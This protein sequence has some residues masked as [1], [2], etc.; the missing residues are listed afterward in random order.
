LRADGVK[1]TDI[2]SDLS[3]TV[4]EVN[5]HVFGL[6]LTVLHGGSKLSPSARPDLRLVE[7]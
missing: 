1:P 7:D 6:V 4:E 3:L 2:A 5:K